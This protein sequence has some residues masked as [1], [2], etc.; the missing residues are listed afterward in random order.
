MK[1]LPHPYIFFSSGIFFTSISLILA[2]GYEFK[3]FYEILLFGILLTLFSFKAP[4]KIPESIYLKMYGWGFAAGIIIDLILGLTL[5]E[6]WRYNYNSLPQY[7]LLYLWIYPICLLIMALT[8][9][10]SLDLLNIKFKKSKEKE[11][12]L[13]DE[14]VF[15]LFC[16]VFV[17]ATFVYSSIVGKYYLGFLL[18]GTV[19]ALIY[20]L[21]NVYIEKRKG[22]TFFNLLHKEPLKV[23]LAAIM[24][25]Y[26]MAFLHEIPNIVAEQWVYQNLPLMDITI[27]KIPI[28]VLAGWIILLLIPLS[29]ILKYLSYEN[30]EKVIED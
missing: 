9:I 25:T 24:S 2:V 12:N 10:I 17:I 28:F 6:L 7:I 27:I 30:L 23:A 4:R 3:N 14:F 8:Y 13:K 15:V 16:F 1:N 20:L 26:S 11:P 5:T 21:L 22:L 18:F 29:V 19:M